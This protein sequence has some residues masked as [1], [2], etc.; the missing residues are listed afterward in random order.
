MVEA[1]NSV[2]MS[3]RVGGLSDEGGKKEIE[4]NLMQVDGVQDV[5]VSLDEKKVTV[6]FDQTVISNDYI[7]RTLNSLGYS[8][9]IEY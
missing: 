6:N 4:H 1:K 5:Q 7:L 3:T 9:Y 2:S 8:P